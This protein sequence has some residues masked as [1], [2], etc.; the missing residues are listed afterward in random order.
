LLQRSELYRHLIYQR[1]NM[2]RD[3]RAGR[4]GAD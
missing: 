2:F 3:G 1:F 4:W